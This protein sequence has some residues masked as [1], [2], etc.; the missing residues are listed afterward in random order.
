VEVA[1]DVFGKEHREHFNPGRTG[2]VFH[3]AGAEI[4]RKGPVMDGN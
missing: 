1:L 3:R 4:W 2:F